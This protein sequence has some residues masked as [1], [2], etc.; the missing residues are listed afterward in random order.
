MASTRIEPGFTPS[1][2]IATELQ[3]RVGLLVCQASDFFVAAGRIEREERRG[4][5]LET[6]RLSP[7]NGARDEIIPSPLP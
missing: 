3:Y 4:A 7:P 2:L 1:N 6:T 5:S